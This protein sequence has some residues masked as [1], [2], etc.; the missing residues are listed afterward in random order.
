MA[1]IV[2][3]ECNYRF[4]SEHLKKCPY[5]G[6]INIEEDLDAEDIVNEKF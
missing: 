6:G 1:K 5:C 4:E 3:T 2:C